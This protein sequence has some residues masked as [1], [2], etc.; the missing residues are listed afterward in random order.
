M[1]VF[2]RCPTDARSWKTPLLAKGGRVYRMSA[3]ITIA[4]MP[5]GMR[6]SA[7]RADGT[8]GFAISLSLSRRE[9][10]GNAGCALHPRSRV[11]Q[12]CAIG[13]HEHTG[14]RKH[15]DIP[16]AMALRL[17]SCSS[18]W[19]ELVVTVAPEKRASQELFAS[20]RGARTTRLDRTQQNH[21]PLKHCVHRIPRPTCRDDGDTP[22]WWVRDGKTYN[23][24]FPKCKAK[25]FCVP[26][27]TTQIS[28]RLLRKLD[29]RRTGFA[30]A[31]DEAQ[32]KMTIRCTSILPSNHRARS[33]KSS[34]ATLTPLPP[35]RNSSGGAKPAGPDLAPGGFRHLP[36]MCQPRQSSC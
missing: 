11:L 12:N 32:A 8:R 15:S 21:S 2:S 23:S 18:R 36:P 7:S 31:C 28:L 34:T 17:T 6:N 25:Y 26:D 3:G 33:R 20:I 5:E 19:S 10:A 1:L 27:W 16:R 30:G 4:G 24:D 35:I 29:F 14:E 9:G 22:L 13:A